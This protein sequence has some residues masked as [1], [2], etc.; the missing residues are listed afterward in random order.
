MMTDD[1]T[2]VPRVLGIAP[3]GTVGQGV[4]DTTA[5]GWIAV[6]HRDTQGLRL[7]RANMVY[8]STLS[9]S[10][11][12]LAVS[13][14]YYYYLDGSNSILRTIRASPRSTIPTYMG[15]LQGTPR[16]WTLVARADDTAI[17][18]VSDDALSVH[19]YTTDGTHIVSVDISA[20]IA[21]FRNIVHVRPGEACFHAAMTATH[22]CY[23]FTF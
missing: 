4:N 1:R 5:T 7:Y 20:P 6:C 9:S 10:C 11:R 21:N 3:D 17:Y 2:A 12:G 13:S 22:R 19:T 8:D 16:P 23:Q 18:T 14:R 15:V